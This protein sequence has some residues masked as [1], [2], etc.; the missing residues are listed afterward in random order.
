ML[1]AR[2][3]EKDTK[4]EGY[5]VSQFSSLPSPNQLILINFYI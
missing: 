2:A 5:Q 4:F 3:K 1:S